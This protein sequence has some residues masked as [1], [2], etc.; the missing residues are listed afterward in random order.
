LNRT[1]SKRPTKRMSEPN[2][3]HRL[4]LTPQNPV[5]NHRAGHR[6]QRQK[7]YDRNGLH[8]VNVVSDCGRK[9]QSLVPFQDNAAK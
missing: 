3:D 8:M 4:T 6:Q 9:R 1:R 7:G 2:R 5:G